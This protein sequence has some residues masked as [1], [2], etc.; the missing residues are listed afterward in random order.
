MDDSTENIH[1]ENREIIGE[2]LM[3][4]S[5]D[6]IYWVGPNVTLRRCTLILRVAA[7][8]LHLYKARLIDCVVEVKQELRNFRWSEAVLKGCRFKG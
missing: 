7:R 6:A 3:L 8:W 4:T 2:R 1:Y 5:K